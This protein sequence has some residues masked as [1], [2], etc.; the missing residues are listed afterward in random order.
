VRAGT[1]LAAI[2]I[3]LYRERAVSGPMSNPTPQQMRG[4]MEEQLLF[5]MAEC[6]LT[7]PA[8][9]PWI[10]EK[11]RWHKR[12]IGIDGHL[13]VS[14]TV[15]DGRYFPEL[16][17]VATHQTGFETLAEA[18]TVCDELARYRLPGVFGD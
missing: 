14:I 8:D 15:K 9:V 16:H 11:G 1:Y 6:G 3:Q 7:E 12:L 2:S 18:K 4:K 10:E 13:D 5:I 17:S